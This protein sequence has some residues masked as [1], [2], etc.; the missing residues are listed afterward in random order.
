MA[1]EQFSNNAQS[2]LSTAIAAGDTSLTVVNASAFPASGQFRIIIDR[3]ILLV[4]A[5][6]GNTFT[7][8]RGQEG[9]TAVAH[10]QSAY[11]THVITAGGLGN[12]PRSMTTTGDL[13]YLNST[14]AVTRLGIGSAGQLLGIAGG[15]PAW[16]TLTSSDV[17]TALGFTPPPNSRNVNTGAGLSGGG[18]LTADLTLSLAELGTA[19]SITNA[20]G[21]LSQ[22]VWNIVKATTT[23]VTVTLPAPAS[24]LVVRLRIDPTSTKLVTLSPHA[25]ETID[26]ASSRVLWAGES[27]ILISDGTNW[28]KVAGKTI[29]MVCDLYQT[30]GQ[31]LANG[32]T[33]YQ[34]LLDTTNIDNTGLMADTANH[35]VT[36]Q[37]TGIYQGLGVVTYQQSGFSGAFSYQARVAKNVA[38]T[39]S[40]EIAEDKK[41]DQAANYPKAAAPFAWSPL[42]SGD[43]ITLG[44]YETAG[45]NVQLNADG[46]PR[47]V[48]LLLIEIPQW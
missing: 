28:F 42:S 2:N 44:A 30:S 43:H 35:R 38:D 33:I 37:R 40:G 24:L 17:T 3:E 31:N 11:V 26:G 25:S 34:V 7:V 4:T 46:T 8:S 14:G 21:N 16:H 45:V 41:Y 12:C 27:A 48:R 18:A 9:T 23:A 6:A 39:S 20:N 10:V 13:E 29:T 5:V 47:S 1:T 22:D 32:S 19:N 36:I 15:V